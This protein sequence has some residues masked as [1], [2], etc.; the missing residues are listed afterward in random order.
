M[1]AVTSLGAKRAGAHRGRELVA[2]P[3]FEFGFLWRSRRGRAADEE[4][5]TPCIAVTVQAKQHEQ[6]DISRPCEAGGAVAPLARTAPTGHLRR[7]DKNGVNDDDDEKSSVKENKVWLCVLYG[8]ISRKRRTRTQLAGC[9]AE[10]GAVCAR[11]T[12]ARETAAVRREVRA[13]PENLT[14]C[15]A[16]V[17]ASNVVSGTDAD[18]HRRGQKKS[19]RGACMQRPRDTAG[20]LFAGRASRCTQ[21]RNVRTR[22]HP[23]IHGE[24]HKQ[25]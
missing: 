19:V 3:V 6:Q 13:A 9:R 12:V 14:H 20:R 16:A 1:R 25:R 11:T 24:N 22:A 21:G 8:V 5:L 7:K 15:L 10:E 17:H 18:R 2:D 4:E 23:H